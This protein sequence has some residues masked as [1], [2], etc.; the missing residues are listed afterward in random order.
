MIPIYQSK[1]IKVH[2]KVIIVCNYSIIWKKDTLKYNTTWN[3]RREN[4]E[5][6]RVIHF[7]TV[8]LLLMRLMRYRFFSFL[9]KNWKALFNFEQLFVFQKPA[10]FLWFYKNDTVMSRIWCVWKLIKT[11]VFA[12]FILYLAFL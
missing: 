10:L 12:H 4:L 9:P 2:K 1:E 3:I 7:Y 11:S 8:I 5:K 6:Y